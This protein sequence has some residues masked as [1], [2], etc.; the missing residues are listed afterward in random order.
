MWILQARILEWVS[1]PFSTGSSPSSQTL[2]A[3]RFCGLA[4]P[5]GGLVA[6]PTRQMLPAPE[7]SVP[8]CTPGASPSSADPVGQGPPLMDHPGPP[9][10]DKRGPLEAP[11]PAGAGQRL[12]VRQSARLDWG[13]SGEQNKRGACP[14]GTKRKATLIIQH[15]I[16]KGKV[17]KGTR[18]LHEC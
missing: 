18:V 13:D 6:T 1:M 17:Q 16:R 4:R 14:R 12:Y 7:G 10:A 2:D 11:L 3:R 9:A 5:L 8:P 15:G